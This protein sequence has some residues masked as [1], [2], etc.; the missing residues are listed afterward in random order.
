MGSGLEGGQA[1]GAPRHRSY[2]SC[3]WRSL[4][5]AIV[6]LLST[7]IFLSPLSRRRPPTSSSTLRRGRS[8]VGVGVVVWLASSAAVGVPSVT[9]RN[10]SAVGGLPS[11]A[12]WAVCPHLV[13]S[14]VPLPFFSNQR[15]LC[16]SLTTRQLTIA[17]GLFPGNAVEGLDSVALG[18][19]T[20]AQRLRD[21]CIEY[22][23]HL[24]SMPNGAECRVS[25][26]RPSPY[27]KLSRYIEQ[28]NPHCLGEARL[29]KAFDV[30]EVPSGAL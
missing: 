23:Y 9:Q 21:S 10:R 17:Q 12:V 26:F 7:G 16:S 13:C 1:G 14:S 3:D 19:K 8:H 22:Q 30:V 28:L 5:H 11:G 24:A 4:G 2:W 27:A 6:G 15:F 18:R 29:P 20:N 25:T